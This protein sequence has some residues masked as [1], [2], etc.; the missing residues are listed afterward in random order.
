MAFDVA[1]VGAGVVGSSIA[2]RLAQAG[3]RVVLLDAGRMGG[4]A[5]WAAAGMLAPGGEFDAPSPWN[6]FALDSLRAYPAFVAELESESGVRIDFQRRGA[7]EVATAADEMAA[8]DARATMQA[9]L[10]IPSNPLSPEQVWREVPRAGRDIA[11]GRFYPEDALVDPRGLMASLRAAC[12]ARGVEIQEGVR[13]SAIRPA[14]GVVEVVTPDSVLAAGAAVLAAGAWSSQIPV[15]GFLTPRAFP[16]RGH[17]MGFQLEPGVLGPILR[18]GHTYLLQRSSGYLVAGAS[19]EE[20]GFDR[21]LDPE[22]LSGIHHSS[23][24]LLPALAGRVPHESW[25]GFRPGI[26][27]DGPVIERV[28]ET[29]LWLAYGHYRNGI[30]LAPATASR[31]AAGITAS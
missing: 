28:G 19:S 23:S 6:C 31:V 14:S 15:E 8:L 17:L 11:G 26:E 13:V 16:V 21:A 2:W 12:A 3:L 7:I 18:C 30:L 4:E 29:A 9:P 22:V 25:L 10:G 24:K 20:S 27:G 1:I 5:S